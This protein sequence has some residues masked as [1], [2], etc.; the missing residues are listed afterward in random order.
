MDFM[1]QQEISVEECRD[2]SRVVL[3]LIAYWRNIW[4]IFDTRETENL[5]LLLEKKSYIN[6]KDASY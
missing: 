3:L 1:S 4:H 2:R 6:K 5:V